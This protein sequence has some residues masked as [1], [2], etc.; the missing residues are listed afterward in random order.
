[1][2]ISYPRARRKHRGWWHPGEISTGNVFVPRMSQ[3]QVSFD[4]PPGDLDLGINLQQWL[5]RVRNLYENNPTIRVDLLENGVV[6]DTPIPEQPVT[7]DDI[8]FE[9]SWDATVL[10]NYDGKSVEALLTSIND[11]GRTRVELASL[12]WKPVVSKKARRK[13][14]IRWKVRTRVAANPLSVRWNV[15]GSVT[16]VGKT[17]SPRW[18]TRASVPDTIAVR[19]DVLQQAGV[20]TD[21]IEIRWNVRASVSDTVSPRWT[22]R[23][24]VSDA[25]SPRWNVRVS[26]SDTISPRWNVAAST[27]YWDST[28]VTLD[29]TTTTFV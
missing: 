8:V 10:Q 16:P 22:I 29:S 2:I 26:V 14:D 21:K 3:A 24:S 20:A 13:L 7:E 18:N 19:W 5:I 23:A 11:K 28:T 15:L 12:K 1:M 25:A 4:D 6:K 27:F 17:I 9:G